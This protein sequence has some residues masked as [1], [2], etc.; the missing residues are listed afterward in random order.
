MRRTSLSALRSAMVTSSWASSGFSW[1]L[2]I[3][4]RE[5]RMAVR[6]VRNSWL[7]VATNS[8]FSRST[9]LRSVMSRIMSSSSPRWMGATRA[10]KCLVG[11]SDTRE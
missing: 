2:A 11:P 8:S 10:S 9:S 4:P 5:P 3:M 6:G 7:T 1:P